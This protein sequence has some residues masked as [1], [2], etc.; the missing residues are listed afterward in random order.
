MA[1]NGDMKLLGVF[2]ASEILGVERSRLAR[3][4]VDGE[5]EEPHARLRMGPVWTRE[6]INRKLAQMY[7]AAGSPHGATAAGRERWAA[8]RR[9]KREARR[10]SRKRKRAEQLAA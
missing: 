9:A 4:L 7:E 6:Q 2:E 5:I 10:G 3:W 1:R 8:E